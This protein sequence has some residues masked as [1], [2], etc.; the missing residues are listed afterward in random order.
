MSQ[1]PYGLPF[2]R[3]QRNQEGFQATDMSRGGGSDSNFGRAHAEKAIFVKPPAYD[4]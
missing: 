3:F 4:D 1:E 2:A